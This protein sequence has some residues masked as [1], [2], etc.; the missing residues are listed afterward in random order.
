MGLFSGSRGPLLVG[1]LE[2]TIHRRQW[3][4]GQRPGVSSAGTAQPASPGAGL[5]NR[6]NCVSWKFRAQQTIL[7]RW[8]HRRSLVDHRLCCSSERYSVQSMSRF[9]FDHV[10]LDT[11]RFSVCKRS[12]S[13]LG[14]PNG[15]LPLPR[16]SHL[17]LGGDHLS[18]DISS[19]SGN[20]EHRGST[21]G[22]RRQQI[23]FRL[24]APASDRCKVLFI[25]CPSDFYKL[26]LFQVGVKSARDTTTSL[27]MLAP[28]KGV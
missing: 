26:T 3:L 1:A 14:I 21:P 16:G 19:G 24:R 18:S 15:I 13:K 9:R 12:V 11:C 28:P 5:D 20:K 10:Y 2:P 25:L 6:S 23:L 7:G 8:V 22:Y 27:D 4:L 17:D